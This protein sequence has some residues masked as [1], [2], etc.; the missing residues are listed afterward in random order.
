MK[1]GRIHTMAQDS[2]Y[3]SPWSTWVRIKIGLWGL[4]WALLWRPS[5]NKLAS[6]WRSQLLRLFGARVQGRP[7]LANTARVKMPWNLE[8]ADRACIS[9]GVEIYN[10]GPC[11][12]GARAS[13]TQ[14]AYLCGGTHELSDPTL[15]LIVGRIE[16]GADAFVGAR[17]MILPGVSV[18]IGAVVGAGSVLTKDV[19]A[20]M[21][22]AGNPAREIGR[23][24]HPD[25][26]AADAQVGPR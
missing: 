13:V 16:V 1:N 5:P 26:P 2:A 18:G 20:W 11:V 3:S 22:F 12:I 21:V 25:A 17:S 7:F 8:I 9:P 14:Y 10:L 23:R 24:K 6:G 4:T 19:P 15:P